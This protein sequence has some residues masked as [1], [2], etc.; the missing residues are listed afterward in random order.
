MTAQG[1]DPYQFLT[2]YRGSYVQRVRETVIGYR[3]VAAGLDS[4]V[5]ALSGHY[6]RDQNRRPRPRVLLT[7]PRRHPQK[8]L[9]GT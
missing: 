6:R 7:E 2:Q 8:A 3:A 9:Q 4:A 1:I 5:V